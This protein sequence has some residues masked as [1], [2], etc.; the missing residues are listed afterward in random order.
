MYAG[1]PKFNARQVIFSEKLKYLFFIQVMDSSIK[2]KTVPKIYAGIVIIGNMYKTMI[3]I[4]PM[5]KSEELLREANNILRA[6]INL[7]Q[8]KVLIIY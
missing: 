7:I 1:I 5:A 3:R 8:S 2:I 6:K 4:A